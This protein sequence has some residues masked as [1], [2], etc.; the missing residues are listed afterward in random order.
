MWN[1]PLNDNLHKTEDQL[2]DSL[3]SLDNLMR[4]ADGK[5]EPAHCSHLED[6]NFKY[7]PIVFS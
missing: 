6:T 1:L 4:S 7:L 5:T 3:T 2:V